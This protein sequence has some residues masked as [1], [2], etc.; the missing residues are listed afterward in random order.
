MKSI[1]PY[2]NF[3]GKCEEAFNYYRSVF[4]GEFTTLMRFRDIPREEGVEVKE[5]EKNRIMHV[6]LPLA[7]GGIL[8]GSDIMES[9]G[10]KLFEGNNCY[11]SIET[12]NEQEADR[13]FS[14]L[15]EGGSVEMPMGR[16]FWGSYFGMSV[17]RFG[18]HWMISFT[19]D[20]KNQ[21]V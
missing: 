18:I 10:Q 6:A 21:E 7:N 20:Q 14:R 5:A 1:N 15:S 3:N 19:Y 8:M 13:I 2:L 11:L 17:D 4:G 12:E 9:Q 16:T